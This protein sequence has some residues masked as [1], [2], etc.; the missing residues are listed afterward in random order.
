M[1][2]LFTLIAL[3]IWTYSYTQIKVSDYSRPHDKDGGIAIQRAFRAIDSIGHGSIEFDGTKTYI[4]SKCIE[5]P[6]I[7]KNGRR[8][9]VLNGNGC[10]LKAKTDSVCIF[11]RIPENQKEALNKMMSTRFT[12]NDFTFMGGKKGINLGA[13]YGSSINRCNFQNQKEAAIDIQFGL[14]TAINHCN[15]TNA[16]KDNYVLRTGEDWGGNGVNSQSNHSVISMSRVYARKDAKTAFKILGSSGVVLRD[17]ISEGSKEIDYS[18][19]VDKQKS[20]TVRLFTLE[21]FHLEHAPIK[22]GIYIKS[23]GI[24]K[25]DGLFYQLARADWPLIQAG[26]NTDQ[27]TVKNI[28]HFVTGTVLQQDKSGDGAVWLLESC[29]KNFYD[30][31]N[32][33]VKNKL[34]I[35]Q[36]KLPYY[37]KGN[38]GKYQIDKTY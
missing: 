32:W 14:N 9:I 16:F 29:H 18:V 34:G 23:A 38:G 17:I 28:P 26:A 15:S 10:V 4:I 20:T 1:K 37:F 35:Y 12:I 11:N 24:S 21:N 19:Y 33:R 6:R 13:S 3:F 36:K 27:I 25:I 2:T 22:A 30:A 31:A 5:L 8:I 7:S